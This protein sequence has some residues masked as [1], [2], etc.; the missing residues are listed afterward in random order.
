MIQSETLK[1]RHMAVVVEDQEINRDLLADILEDEDYVVLTAENG[2]IAMDLIRQNKEKLSIILLDLIMPVMDGFEVLRQLRE[3]E[4]LSQIPVIVLTGEADAELEALQGGAVDF[5]TKPF[6]SQDIILARVRRI[7]E[8]SENRQLINAAERD[9]LTGL[10]TKGFFFQY[11]DQI[12]RYHKEWHMD[13]IVL[14]IN[15]FHTVNDLSGRDFGDKV[16]RALS[17]EIMVFLMDTVGLAGRIEADRFDIYCLHREEHDYEEILHQFQERMN[18]LSDHASVLLR[19]GVMPWKEG[20]GPETMFDQA[21]VACNMAREEIQTHLKVFDDAIHEKELH[22]QRLMGELQTAVEEKQFIVYYQ[23]KYNIQCDPPRLASAEALIRWKHPEM[24]MISPGEFIPLFEDNGL[25]SVVDNYVWEDAAK[26]IAEWREK[27]GFT[28]PVS[29]NL[30]RMDV[31]DPDLE[32]NLLRLIQDNGLEEGDLKLEVTESA[33]TDK[34]KEMIEVI[35]HLRN[36]GFQI[37][38]D[39]FGSGYSSLNMLSSLPIDVLKMDMKFI[40]NVQKDSKEFRLVKLILDIA[41][42]LQVPVVAEGVETEEQMK[43][44]Q[45]AG[46]DLVQGYYFSRPLPAEEFEKL[47]EKE[48]HIDRED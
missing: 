25:I 26:Q 45:E 28:V 2:A 29:V 20:A 6:D 13:A 41:K 21:R 39:D 4:E 14:N 3:D 8:L 12:Y 32:E 47:I 48:M 1:R 44:L 11:A 34:A 18:S 38:M 10:Y 30:S 22:Q 43:L 46:C 36:L 37:E 17:D 23:P 27:K 42:F 19:M 5:I 33:Y 31:F 16:L 40:Q 35:E 7:V 15:Q 9:T 24:G